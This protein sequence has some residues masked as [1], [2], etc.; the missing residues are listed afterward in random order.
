M[1]QLAAWQSVQ[2]QPPSVH[3]TEDCLTVTIRSPAGAAGLPVMV[4]LHGGNHQDGRAEQPDEPRANALPEK[5]VVLV[6]VQ[7]RV[8]LFGYFAHP[9]LAGTNFGT[10]DQVAG[11]EW[12]RE[13]VAAFGG[14]PAHLCCRAVSCMS[15]GAGAGRGGGS[16]E[17]PAVMS[18]LCLLL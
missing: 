16:L 18:V 8:G 3:Q 14:G 13:N 15:W 5:G 9:E 4:W 2:P 1:E 7:Y 6:K 17:R 12:I 10:L 11:L